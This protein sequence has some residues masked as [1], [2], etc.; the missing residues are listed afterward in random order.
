M[1]GFR[2]IQLHALDMGA[3]LLYQ[4][5]CCSLRLPFYS[6]CRM[7]QHSTDSA[8]SINNSGQLVT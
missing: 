4:K 7:E 1:Q 2:R 6:K 5:Q 3:T 8:I